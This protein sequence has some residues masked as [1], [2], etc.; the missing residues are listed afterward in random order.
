MKRII[1][2]IALFYSTFTMA[3][4]QVFDTAYVLPLNGKFYL[5]NRIEY[6][7]NSY[8]EKVTIIGDTAQFYLSALQKFESTAN[9]FANF[10][11]G[12]Y[13][14]SK[15]ITGAIRE[16]NGITQITGKSP[17]DS[18]GLQTFEHLS[19]STFRWVI[20][21]G[22]GA[23]PI[24]WNKTANGSLRYTVQGSTAKVLFGFGKALIRLNAFPTTGNFLDL[25]WDEGR[26]LYVSQDGKSIVRR[27][28]L[29]R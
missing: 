25:Y 14:Y 11:N 26:K 4:N 18:L 27:L 17:I 20:N 7:D 15:E 19:D 28:V 13:F 8:Y 22:S 24:T 5:L 3:Q 12:S 23:I 1:Y 10:V 9:S 6:D 2:F 29:N 21:T 16:N